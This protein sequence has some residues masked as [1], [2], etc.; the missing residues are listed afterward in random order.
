LGSQVWGLLDVD[1]EKMVLPPAFQ[2]VHE[3]YHVAYGQ[4]D[5]CYKVDEPN[6]EKAADFLLAL[7]LGKLEGDFG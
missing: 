1:Q 4:S 5:F 7:C 3:V 6:F 2:L